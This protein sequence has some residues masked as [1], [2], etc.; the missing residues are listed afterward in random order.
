MSKVKTLLAFVVLII[1]STTVF[2]IEKETFSNL[3][4][5]T[6]STHKGLSQSSVLSIT[7][8]AQGFIWLGTKDGLNRM[9][10]YNFTTYKNELNNPNSISNN[11]IIFLS[12]D[13]LGNLFVGT[14]GGGLNLFIKEE[15]KFIR[16][17]NLKTPD[18]TV[19]FV[20]QC[21]DGSIWVGTT[22]GLF[23]G[24]PNSSKKFSYTFTNISKKSVYLDPKGSILPFDREMYSA[25]T[26]KQI[27]NQ[28][29]LIG[30]F[31]GLF[32][33]RS[34]DLSF[35]QVNIE[36]LI[37]AKVNALEWDH[38]NYLWVATSEGL[39]KLTIEGEEITSKY[40][41]NNSNPKWKKL[42]ANWIERLKCDSNGNMW[43]A[44][45]GSGL[46]TFNN[47]GA[48]TVYNNDETM[49]N[50]LGDNIINSM[51]IDRSGVLWLGTE[52]RGVVTL[53]LFRKK[54]NHLENNSNAGRN[55][56]SNLITAITGK[57][58]I[59]WVGAAYNGL[60]YLEFLPDNTI[61]TDHIPEIPNS[62]G[63]SS[64]E[65]IS[66]LLDKKDILWIGT[67]SNSLVAYRKDLGFKQYY[68]GGYPFALHQDREQS[69]WVGTW[70]KGLGI[71]DTK[72]DT[73]NLYAN[74]PN[75]SRTL[76]GNVILSIFDDNR[77]NLWVGTKGRGLNIIPLELIKQ[78]YNNF[79]SFE[80]DSDKSILHND[81]YCIFQ[82]S[83]DVIW[84]GT[85]GGLNRLDLYSDPLA[86]KELQK[87]RAKFESYTEAD[88][89]A[90]NLIYG[91]EED[92][93]GN[94][95]IST[96]KGLSMFNKNTNTFKNYNSN[97]GLQSN[98]FHSN[99]FY[100]SPDNKLFFGGVNGLSF[101]S[102]S[103]ITSNTKP[104]NT[105]ISTLKV[106][107]TIV[108]PKQKVNGKVILEKDISLA[109]KI[110][111]SSKHKEFSLGFSAMHFANLEGVH[112]AYRLLGFNDEWRYL[113]ANEH[114]VTYTNLWEGDYIFQVKA[115][116]NDGIWNEK[117]NEL[118]I[119]VNPPSWRH[120][121]AYAI[122]LAIAVIGLLLFR[123][124]TLIGV[125]DK[126]R[127]LIE[128]IE[129]SN[130]IENTEAKMR[131]FT[132][133][134]HEIRTPL[135]LISNPLEDVI[136]KGNIDEKSK[137]SLQ[138]VS[139]NVNRL[140][141]LTNQLLQLRKIDKGGIEPQYSEVNV[142]KF[143]KEITGFFLQKAL[144]KEITLRFNSELNEDEKF[145]VDSELLTTA[146]YNVISNAYKFTPS[147]GQITIRIFKHVPETSKIE[148]W[149]KKESKENKQ[150][151][152]IEVSDTGPGIP[153]DEI[154]TIFHRFYQSKHKPKKELAGSGIGLSIV[155]E[156]I[157]LLKGKIETHS[158]IGEG[159]TFTFYLPVGDE[160]VKESQ[161][162][163]QT[164]HPETAL[165]N[166]TEDFEHQSNSN[167]NEGK[168]K[169]LPSLLVVE[170]DKDLSDYLARNL[171]E[172]Y[173][174][175]VA[176]DGQK[177]CEKALEILPKLIISDVMMPNTDGIELCQNLKQNDKTR[178]IPIILLTAKAADEAKIEG[179]KSGA[180]LYVSKPF[181][182][183]VLK[184][185]IE[186]LLSTRKLLVDIFS[187]QI[188]LQPRDIQI[189]SNDEKF[190]T[191][192]NEVID[193]HL[194]EADFDVTA[195]VEKMNLSHSTVLKKVKSLTKMSL[196]EFVKTHRLK[197]A[198]QILE[199]EHFQIAEVAYM[200]G[201]SDPKYFSKCFSKEFGKTPTE[202]VQAIK[203]KREQEEIE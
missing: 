55:L 199:K 52:S 26:I 66:L 173:N 83:E 99:A 96:T 34:K 47:D 115:S 49:S 182:I 31:K 166:L 88:G 59:V 22:Q 168:S 197:R 19:S 135:T 6:Y 134:S 5:N 160:H 156:Y 152:C 105:V 79:I 125:S 170:D 38:N 194:S 18:G 106:S 121:W 195:M 163:A 112:Y 11:E 17:D 167:I 44:T 126:N 175:S 28:T 75:D 37:Q 71:I 70:G 104:S 92:R 68:T 85:G 9:D 174:V 3:R 35:T 89:L 97:D 61:I 24:I 147:K 142:V 72:K 101:F 132:N 201:F 183:D 2:G 10:G 64:S 196:V 95:W 67:A 80:H 137:N 12:G 143:L 114:T 144:N 90:A 69:I 32:I 193:E 190:L 184:S 7:Q 140:L 128:H 192:M 109:E 100:S 150:W 202:Y 176:Y 94:L 113:N 129:R 127:L 123:R 78:G 21:D 151:Y 119:E 15:N 76:S 124:Y 139:K 33:F 171:S 4:F 14:R 84:I 146:I 131:F 158:K 102:P 45:R 8:D 180:D 53:D 23:K 29:Y 87:G 25:I 81:V 43:V 91:I 154:Q 149:K 60:N 58:N 122:Y 73:I 30:T 46:I 181:K 74:Q 56:T 65:I 86:L 148:R 172:N 40:F 141:K 62:D 120:P 200:V 145:W 41:F 77:G 153:S 189:S 130:L 138:L 136:S 1:I 107:N 191:K 117:P 82:D 177:G 155:K 51:L 20:E 161:I 103:E 178:H 188:L 159:S 36:S 57:D 98:E 42:N 162:A 39:A 54:F 13:S 27:Q 157:D 133:I 187:K 50:K 93:D 48:F 169:D 16:Y 164:I 118:I 203:N 179:Y 165:N 111:L 116:N 63:R 198:A 108:M 185:Q 186:Q 110:T